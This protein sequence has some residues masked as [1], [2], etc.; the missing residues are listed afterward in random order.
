MQAVPLPGG[1]GCF[2]AVPAAGSLFPPFILLVLAGREATSSQ[3]W[4]APP[5]RSESPWAEMQG[6]HWGLGCVEQ[7][8]NASGAAEGEV[9]LPGFMD[10]QR[11]FGS[12]GSI[13]AVF[14]V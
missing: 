7:T 8:G 13:A 12:S 9:S 3:S 6:L 11:K 5:D 14:Q 10:K 2:G 4:A 1:L